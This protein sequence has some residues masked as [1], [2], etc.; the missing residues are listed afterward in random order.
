MIKFEDVYLSFGDTEILKNF[1]LHIKK[2]EKILL[3]A[4]S[5]RGKS[6]LIKLLMGFIRPQKGRIF[7]DGRELN[8]DTID[9]I[10]GRIAW[11]NQDINLRKLTVEELLEDIKGFS[12]NKEVDLY[13][14][15]YK[16]LDNFGLSR[17]YMKKKVDKLSGGEKQRL[18]FIIA[19]LL[20]RDVLLLDEVTSSLDIA[21]K[22]KVEEWINNTDKTVVLIS[23]D[24]HWNKDNFRVVRW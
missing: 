16:L 18:G 17:G 4:P 14:D 22:K 6:S 15:L 5:G 13:G 11:V 3:D 23:H 19:I 9:E 24:T 1:S 12:S 2:G 8:K 7:F 10:R 21:M 20:D